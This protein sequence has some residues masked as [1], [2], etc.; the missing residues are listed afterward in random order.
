MA[1]G[2]YLVVAR[3]N[4][5]FFFDAFA[6]EIQGFGLDVQEA[7]QQ[8]HERIAAQNGFPQVGGAVAVGIGRVARAF[9]KNPD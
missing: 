2:V 4:Q 7:P 8:V 5:V 1:N 6:V 9:V 3:K